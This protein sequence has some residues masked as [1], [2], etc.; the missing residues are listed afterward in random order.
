VTNRKWSR[1]E[2]WAHE[3]P[4]ITDMV[5]VLALAILSAVFIV[6]LWWELAE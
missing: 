6:K 2:I 1:F 5:S 3:H 4:I